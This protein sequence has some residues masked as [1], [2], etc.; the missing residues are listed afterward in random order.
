MDV[1]EQYQPTAHTEKSEGKKLSN[2]QEHADFSK[3]KYSIYFI[4]LTSWL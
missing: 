4:T 2:F 3:Q 1:K